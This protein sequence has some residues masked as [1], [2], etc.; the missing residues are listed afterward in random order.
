MPIITFLSFDTTAILVES[1]SVSSSYYFSFI[2]ITASSGLEIT[3]AM[4]LPIIGGFGWL[5]FFTALRS[6]S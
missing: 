1:D 2:F 3:Q 4:D 6:N 5:G